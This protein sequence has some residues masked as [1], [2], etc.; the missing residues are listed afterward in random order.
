MLLINEEIIKSEENI[1]AKSGVRVKLKYCIVAPTENDVK[2]K[3]AIC[4]VFELS[5]E[6]ITAPNKKRNVAYAK[7]AFAWFCVRNMH[8]KLTE[9]AKEIG[10]TNHTT[11]IAAVQKVDDAIFLKEPLKKKILEVKELLSK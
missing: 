1:L 6:E 7:A 11:V 9:V 10:Y 4:E 2:L 8:M 5:W 3:R